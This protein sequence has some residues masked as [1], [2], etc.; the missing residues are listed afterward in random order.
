MSDEKKKN[1]YGADNL[2]HLSDREHVRK[3]PGM[4][5]G[6]TF[7]RGLHHLVYEVVDNSIDE[8]M[9][10][11]ASL[12][13]VVI[14]PDGSI[15]VED[16]GR[17]IPVEKH[18]ALTEEFDREV[19]TL[20]GVMTV[21]KFG[22]K[23]DKG[24]YQTSGGL[25]GVGVTVVNFL[26]QWCKVEVGRDGY[27]YRQEYEY[28]EP[29][30]LVKRGEKS[31]K[32]GTK[33]TFK[34][35]GDIFETTKYQ[36]DILAKRMQDLAFLNK[37]VTIEIRDDRSD[38]KETYCYENGI[39]DFVHHLNRA[40]DVLHQDVFYIEG[41]ETIEEDN[42]VGYEIA[43]Q[44]T[45]DYTEHLHSYVNNIHT[46]EG[47]THE[48]G[49]RKALTRV[50]NTY[51]LKEKILKDSKEVPTGDDVREGMTVILSAKVAHPQF[52]GQTKT[53]LGNREV[54][55]VISANF[56]KALEKYLE[57]NPKN[58]R[59]IIQKGIIAME[60][61]EAAKKARQLMRKRKDVLG[62]GSL[63]G[64]LRDCISKDMEKCELYLV[65]GDS[66]GGSAE[67][68]RLK[69]YQA[70]LPLRGKIINAYKARVDKV[71]ANE[72]VQAM[73]NAIGC[74]FG[75]D[76]NLEKLRYNK[77]IIMT[78]ADVDG[79]HIR[80][81]LL[82]FFY[83]QMYSLMERGHVYVAQ[84]PLFRVKQG[85]KIYY[86]QSEDEMKNQLLEKGLADAVFIPENGDKLEGEKMGALCRTLSGMEE[87]LLAL[88]RRGINLKIHAQ[89]QNVETGKL[90]MFH[91]FEG[92]DDYW[93]SER[94]AVDAF[95]DERTP[96]EPVP[97]E[98]TEEGTEEEALEDV[99]SSIHVVELHE[100]RTINAGLKD[101]QKYGLDVQSLLPVERTGVENPRYI[102]K[103]GDTEIPLKELRGLLNAVRAAGEKGL[104]LTRFK[105][106]GEMNA[107]EL[108]DTTLD[109]NQ[110]TLVRVTMDDVAAADE[111]FRVLMGDKVEPRREFIEKHALDVQN[112]DV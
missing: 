52:E 65:E 27:V 106:L 101:L 60:A 73:I 88:E 71:L 18:D 25:H 42:V 36:F 67:G 21:L 98:S 111:M 56:G 109:P 17:G 55:S 81:L 51:G 57:E 47:G 41:S 31:N 95:I 24:A 40:S 23:F 8:A 10:D 62:G 3:R 85:K 87:A 84:P 79:S 13:S 61:R 37:G 69:Q 46:H 89:R 11:Y 93:F 7:N 72:E 96:D 43:L 22:G 33:T 64:K 82:C 16:N 50:L 34:P 66:A 100:V 83:R 39:I 49:F 12:I 99:A 77:I 112:L 6:D 2:Q 58:A 74:G 80:T 45:N 14:N 38:Q 44:Y 9:A 20:E 48:T 26:S 63:P 103:R 5:I 76:Q 15:T 105:G 19:S 104:Q 1:E 110:R 35:D 86:I 75:D 70:I 107:E 59:I 32:T 91:V 29:V 28:G 97:P 4:Y 30:G 54:E 108:R 68:G 53:K 94:D 78:D 90:P 92:T 102:L